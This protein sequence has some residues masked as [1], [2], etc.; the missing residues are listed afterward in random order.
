MSRRHYDEDDEERFWSEEQGDLLD[1]EEE[2][3]EEE[4]EE[5]SSDEFDDL[6]DDDDLAEGST[7]LGDIES[8][9]D[10]GETLSENGNFEEAINVFTSV[11]EHFPESPLGYYNLG[12]AH[13]LKLR[14]EIE[15]SE[16]WEDLVDEEGH[17]EEAVTCF[18]QALE[19]QEDYVPALN[20]LAT[21]YA[22]RGKYQEA[23][24]LWERSLEIDPDQ[25]EI[26]QDLQ[27]V[28][29]QMDDNDPREHKKD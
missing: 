7:G 5:E 17:Y 21:A 1:D 29:A 24:E 28:Q 26:R 18:E 3:G 25:S 16:L 20:N 11:V 13:F 10:E 15:N 23:I 19:L 4:D 9:I 22:M 2:E 27:N 12:V 8:M 14:E 6:D